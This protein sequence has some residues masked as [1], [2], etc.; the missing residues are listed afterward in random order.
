MEDRAGRFDNA[1]V[2]CIAAVQ[3][4]YISPKVTGAFIF[5][6]SGEMSFFWLQ[7]VASNQLVHAYEDPRR[8]SPTCCSALLFQTTNFV[9]PLVVS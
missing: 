3:E 4:Y 8:S 7:F 2:T 6:Y 9:S 1:M 5:P